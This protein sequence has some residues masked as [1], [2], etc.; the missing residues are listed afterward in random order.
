MYP[1]DAWPET[2]MTRAP[3]SKERR[4]NPSQV[5]RNRPVQAVRRRRERIRMEQIGVGV[6][7]FAHGH[8][9]AY[10]NQIQTFEDARLVAAWDDNE[11]RGRTSA[12]RFG[13]EFVPDRDARARRPDVDA[14]IVTSE[15]NRHADLVEA[16]VAAGKHV[17]CQKPM[18][19]TLAD[20]DRIIEAVERSGVHFQMAFQMRC[21]PLNQQI[22]RGWRRGR[23]AASGRCAAAIASTSCSTR[24][25]RRARPPGT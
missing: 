20:C 14:V 5:R 24:T 18:A 4:R 2:T 8:V 1:A 25:W 10:C 17:L 15:T 13:M 9:Q 3:S 21:D 16:P 6:L 22:K 12:A 11:E 23:S 7:S 19:T